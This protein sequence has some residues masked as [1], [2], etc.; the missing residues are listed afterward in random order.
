[1]QAPSKVYRDMGIGVR[2][3]STILTTVDADAE[4]IWIKSIRRMMAIFNSFSQTT[5]LV[6]P[7][8]TS[9]RRV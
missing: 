6:F 2:K 7:R 1:M 9:M 8:N 3:V 4:N 5:V